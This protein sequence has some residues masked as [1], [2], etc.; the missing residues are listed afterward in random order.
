M[1]NEVLSLD[2]KK[3]C[4]PGVTDFGSGNIM[5]L[6][7]QCLRNT[8]E[9]TNCTICMEFCPVDAFLEQNKRLTVRT[10]CLRCGACIGVCPTSALAASTKTVQLINKQLLLATL[11]TNRLALTCER[12]GALLRLAAEASDG[13]QEAR[14]ALKELDDAVA[15]DC[16]IKVPCLAMVTRELWFSLLGEIGVSSLEE[17]LVYLPPGQCDLCP[18][19]AQ[20]TVEELF[21]EAITTAERWANTTVGFI[22]AAEDLPRKK[23]PNVRRYLTSLEE[24]SRRDAFLGFVREV[25]DSWEAVGNSGNQALHETTV[26]RDR[27]SAFKKTRLGETTTMQSGLTRPKVV[28]LR[29]LMIEAL[30]RN[31]ANAATLVLTVSATND[32]TCT[33]CGTCAKVCPVHARRL[34]DLKS[35][36]KD[37]PQDTPPAQHMVCDPLYCVGCS[38]CLQACPTASCYFTEVTGEEFLLPE[39]E[40][41]EEPAEEPETGST[42]ADK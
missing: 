14:A 27:R 34:V 16:L 25:R 21:S 22:A 35:A 41:V 6:S 2:I 31:P 20:G 10:N 33:R 30:G 19:N 38:A 7:T 4:N 26:Q 29:F 18:A 9:R 15:E 17:A 37:E 42:A 11:R 28:P 1:E 39:E 32:S 8:T 12:T 23:Q 36:D 40:P 24:A 3:R 5:A 13:E